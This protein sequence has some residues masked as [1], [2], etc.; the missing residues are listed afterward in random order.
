MPRLMAGAIEDLHRCAA[1]VHALDATGALAGNVP[2]DKLSTKMANTLSASNRLRQT[3]A[4]VRLA[5]VRDA[6]DARR[7]G[8]AKLREQNL[9]ESIA[10]QKYPVMKPGGAK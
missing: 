1:L 6:D 3:Y 7:G 4:P 5:S 9:D 2:P 8:R 10:A